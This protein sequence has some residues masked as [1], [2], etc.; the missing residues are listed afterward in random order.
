MAES[1][2][3]NKPFFKKIIL[4]NCIEESAPQREPQEGRGDW[5]IQHHGQRLRVTWAAAET[6]Y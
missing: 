6:I 1:K 4:E 3:N 2:Y 5:I